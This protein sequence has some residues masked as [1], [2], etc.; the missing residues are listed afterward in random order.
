M[1]TIAPLDNT[2][3][4]YA[5]GSCTAIPE[6]LGQKP[7]MAKPQAE[8]WM[9]AHP[10]APSVVVQGHKRRTLAELIREHPTDLLGQA[11]ARK[12]ENR[13]PYLF[14]VLAAEKPLS[15]QAHP[16]KNQAEAGYRRDNEEGI[17]LD[18]P[19]RNYR[20]SNHK[21]ECICALTPFWALNG[22]R[23]VEEILAALDR[24][25][26]S[27]TG[28]AREM[29][30]L[31][32]LAE[33]QG[34]KE[35][36]ERLMTMA[37]ER[38]LKMIHRAVRYAEN[39]A[40]GDPVS[41]WMLSLWK[42]YPTDIGVLSPLFLNLIRLDPGEAMFLSAGELHAYLKGVCIELMANS[43]NVL[44]GGLTP[45]HVDVPELLRVLNFTEREIAILSP[46]PVSTS[47]SVYATPADE[48]SLSVISIQEAD[49]H[50]SPAKRSIEIIL[51]TEGAG[52]I[53]TPGSGDRLSFRKGT[54]LLVPAAVPAYAIRGNAVLYKA[55][56]P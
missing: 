29:T 19:N 30:R 23:P 46:R 1:N 33:G 17:Q 31:K 24:I 44:R 34:L 3:M 53:E 20:D 54:S 38:Q 45:K 25:F 13:M 8:M 18:A 16:S 55:S 40:S 5:W 27:V 32:Q 2:V 43:D 14:K 56:V 37:P 26:R 10:K 6:L 4:T 28:L 41:R 49:V 48:F 9:G 51:C 47:E 35:L 36:F 15:I 22:F 11:A 39:R 7:D 12:F 52:H 50:W 42:E 21:P